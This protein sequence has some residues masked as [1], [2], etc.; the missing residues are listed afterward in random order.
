MTKEEMKQTGEALIA[1]SEGKPVQ[2]MGTSKRFIP[3]AAWFDCVNSNDHPM[4]DT[5][6]RIKPQPKKR[7]IEHDEFPALF[8]IRTGVGGNWYMP[9]FLSTAGFGI[10][11]DNASPVEFVSWERVKLFPDSWQWSPD[12]KQVN[13]F[14]VE[15]EE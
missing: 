2:W 9:I 10:H 15:S 6:Y 3:N 13:S 14:W 11:L 4:E 12:R 1:L 5:V 8:W 7:L